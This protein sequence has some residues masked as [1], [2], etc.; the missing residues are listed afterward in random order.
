MKK[1]RYFCWDS[2]D[3]PERVDPTYSIKGFLLTSV[4]P[5][6]DELLQE[7]EVLNY[8]HLSD[9]KTLSYFGEREGWTC[10]NP[11]SPLHGPRA[12]LDSITRLSRSVI[13]HDTA[14]S[15]YKFDKIMQM[16]KKRGWD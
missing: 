8:C 1:Y 4:V 15:M 2:T 6:T 13:Y 16:F 11:E 14:C 7:G 9:I 10:C 12:V 5:I 3:K